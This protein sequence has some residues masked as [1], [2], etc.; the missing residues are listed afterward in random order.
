MKR[1]T[2]WI[3]IAAVVLLAVIIWITTADGLWSAPPP[4]QPAPSGSPA[5]S[6][7]HDSDSIR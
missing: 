7:E 3:V 6:A 5:A 4:G 1:A 2:T